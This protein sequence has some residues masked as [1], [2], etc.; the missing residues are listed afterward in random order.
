MQRQVRDIGESDDS[1]IYARVDPALPIVGGITVLAILV[2]V[3]AAI[4]SRCC[5]IHVRGDV[6]G[7]PPYSPN[8]G[9]DET[10]MARTPDPPSYE[11]PVL[12]IWRAPP[13]AGSHPQCLLSHPRPVHFA[14]NHHDRPVNSGARATH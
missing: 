12:T 8:P 7:L 5:K 13:N 9:A 1:G 10:T 4:S 11:L 14:G 2:C 3:G 6:E